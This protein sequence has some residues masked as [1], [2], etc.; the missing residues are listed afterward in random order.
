VVNY[1]DASSGGTRMPRTNWDTLSAY[2]IAIAPEDVI[3]KFNCHIFPMID[4]V[5]QNVFSIRTLSRLRDALLP[6]LMSGEVRVKI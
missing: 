3:S 4:K 1:A 2:E 6:R 5:E